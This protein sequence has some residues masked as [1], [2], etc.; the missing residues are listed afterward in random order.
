MLGTTIKVPSHEGDREI[1]LPPGI[2][3]GT[4]FALRGHGLPGSG[5]GPPGDLVIA[6]RVLV[7]T[8]SPTSNARSPRSSPSRS[9]PKPARR[10]RRRELF[11]PRPPGLSVDPAGGEVSS[12][13]G[14]DRARGADGAGAERRRGGAGARVRRV[15]DL[16]RRGRAAGAGRDRGGG[17]RCAGRGRRDRGPR[18][19]GR[20]LAGL[21]Q[22]APGRRAGSGCARPGRSRARTRSTSSST[23]AAPSGP[24]PTRR[25]G[26]ASSCCSSWPTAGEADGPLTDLGTGSGVLAIAAAKLGWG[27]VRGYDHEEAAIEAAAANAAANGVASSSSAAT[28]ARACRSWRRRPSPT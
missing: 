20:P 3:A 18:R 22:A 26:S 10:S 17:G 14:R 19:L 8:T 9:A 5:G 1:E 13:A 6:I 16:R 7:P 28:C 2:Q 23:P 24:A 11:L 12:G 25:P 15:R 21:P 4:Q 27:P